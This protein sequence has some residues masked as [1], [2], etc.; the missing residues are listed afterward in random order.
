MMNTQTHI[1]FFLNKHAHSF[2]HTHM[3]SINKQNW[4]IQMYRSYNKMHE[5]EPSS[6]FSCIYLYTCVCYLHDTYM[7]NMHVP[8]KKYM[9]IPNHMFF[10]Y[11]I[12][13]NYNCINTLHVCMYLFNSME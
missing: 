7:V 3:Q 8:R 9:C 12:I 11:T 5:P 13:I 10:S 1:P 2:I 6:G 4:F